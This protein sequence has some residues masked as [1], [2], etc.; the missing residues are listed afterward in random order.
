MSTTELERRMAALE[1]DV[2]RIST[3][4][5]LQYSH[6]DEKLSDVGDQIQALRRSV[7]AMAHSESPQEPAGTAK[8]VGL[9]A[10]LVALSTTL[11]SIIE[12]L[13][14]IP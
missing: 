13:I 1:Q 6:L 2:T 9:V 8:M 3:T 12:H 10:A 4:Q 14:A 7:D 5:D 11:A